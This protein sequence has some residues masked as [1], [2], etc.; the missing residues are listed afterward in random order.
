MPENGC[1]DGEH[2]VRIAH[3]EA[4]HT[5]YYDEWGSALTAHHPP[6]GPPDPRV[7]DR[8]IRPA[9]HVE[10]S[11]QGEPGE[12]RRI[13]DEQCDPAIAAE[14]DRERKTPIANRTRK[15]P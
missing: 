3:G 8:I 2:R 12:G 13:A 1:G 6:R 11:D 10:A 5:R 14:V 9:T 15:A 7:K 4:E